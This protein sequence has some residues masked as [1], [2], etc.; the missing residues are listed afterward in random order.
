MDCRGQQSN[1]KSQFYL[2]RSSWVS[3]AL[4]CHVTRKWKTGVCCSHILTSTICLT[5]LDM[6]S[7]SC[8]GVTPEPHSAT[9]GGLTWVTGCGTIDAVVRH[10]GM[11]TWETGKKSTPTIWHASLTHGALMWLILMYLNTQPVLFSWRC[12]TH[13]ENLNVHPRVKRGDN[14]CKPDGVR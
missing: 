6:V 11:C 12:Y 4:A 14:K 2:S 10:E 7:G 1:Q 3:S 8:L 13:R 9:T 5:C